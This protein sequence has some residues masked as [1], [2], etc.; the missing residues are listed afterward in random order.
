M[1]LRRY[2][3]LTLIP[4]PTGRGRRAVARLRAHLFTRGEGEQEK[5]YF[6]LMEQPMLGI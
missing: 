3:A 4:S 6:H 1:E 5:I 2:P